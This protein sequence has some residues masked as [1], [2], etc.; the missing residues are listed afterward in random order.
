MKKTY[1]LLVEDVVL[2]VVVPPLDEEVRMELEEW[3]VKLDLLLLVVVEDVELVVGVV[4]IEEEVSLDFVDLEFVQDS[5]DVVLVFLLEVLDALGV[6][7]EHPPTIDGTALGPA[8]IGIT[9][10]PQLAA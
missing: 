9:F 3:D 8:P 1:L 10:V 5:L 2:L 7:T 4:P 6:E